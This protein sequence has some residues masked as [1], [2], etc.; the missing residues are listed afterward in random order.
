MSKCNTLGEIKT[1][2]GNEENGEAHKKCASDIVAQMKSG[3][4]LNDMRF[5]NKKHYETEKRNVDIKMAF[6]LGGSLALFMI[7]WKM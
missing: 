2:L 6:L 1:Y 4:F 7:N 3:D 5:R